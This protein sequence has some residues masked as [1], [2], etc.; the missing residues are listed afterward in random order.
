MMT[1][2]ATK[3]AFPRGRVGIH[4]KTLGNHDPIVRKCLLAVD[5]FIKHIVEDVGRITFE[6]IAVGS[7]TRPDSGDTISL[8]KGVI[9]QL[10]RQLYDL[11][12]R[13]GPDQLRRCTIAAAKQPLRGIFVTLAFDR[14]GA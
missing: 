4:L 13:L 8:T 6:R 3:L 2:T 12:T 11:A 7:P 10:R 1:C 14:Y 9:G 5:I